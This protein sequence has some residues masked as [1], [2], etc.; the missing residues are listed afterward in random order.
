MVYLQIR[1]MRSSSMK[2]STK[3]CKKTKIL[4]VCNETFCKTNYLII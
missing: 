4:K 1:C 3:I 2:Y